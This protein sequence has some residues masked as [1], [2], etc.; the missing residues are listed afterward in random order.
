MKTKLYATGP[1]GSLATRETDRPYSNVVWIRRTEA[2]W[3]KSLESGLKYAKEE[4]AKYER[5]LAETGQYTRRWGADTIEGWISSKKEGIA[6]DEEKLAA[7]YPG[8]PWKCEH[9]CGRRDLA[10]KQH[11]KWSSDGYETFLGDVL[12]TIEKGS[13][14]IGEGSYYSG[15]VIVDRV[16]TSGVTTWIRFYLDGHGEEEISAEE[17]FKHFRKDPEPA[18]V[19]DQD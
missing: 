5:D 6:K 9:W 7:G 8:S 1:E 12:P 18:L 10:L 2:L 14:W 4:L 17:F 11:S 13:A 3:L 19:V 15:R 16:K